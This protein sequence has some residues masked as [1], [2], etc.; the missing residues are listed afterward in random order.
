MANKSLS[1]S[2]TSNSKLDKSGV[3]TMGMKLALKLLAATVGAT[4]TFT[5][6]IRIAP[7]FNINIGPQNL[8]AAVSQGESQV[9]KNPSEDEFNKYMQ[10]GKD[11]NHAGKADKGYEYYRLAQ[12]IKHSPDDEA[13]L[14]TGLAWSRNIQH[15]SKEALELAEKALASDNSFSYAWQN[16]AIAELRLGNQEA[17][18]TSAK[19]ASLDP[20]VQLD[21]PM[22]SFCR[23]Q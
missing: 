17:A 2:V 5:V 19:R 10:M 15:R 11:S 13:A 18:C 1:E 3:N 22:K 14:L 9:Q 7:T 21:A 6:I 20:E 8:F 16:K 4:A 12:N 23:I